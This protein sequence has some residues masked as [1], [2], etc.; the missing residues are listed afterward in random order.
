M[1]TS[2]TG[3]IYPPGIPVAFVLSLDDD[4]AI[5][6]PIADP[7]EAT[8]AMALPVFEPAAVAEAGAP[9]P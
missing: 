8:F 2:G 9:A 5:A 6:R 3:G 1:V 7:G 4:G